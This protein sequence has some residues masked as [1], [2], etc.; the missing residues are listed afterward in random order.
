MPPESRPSLPHPDSAPGAIAARWFSQHSST[1]GIEV[2]IHFSGD[3]LLIDAGSARQSVSAAGLTVANGGYD[4]RTL[5]LSWDDESGL[6]LLHIADIDAQRA[7]RSAAPPALAP[8]LARWQRRSAVPW[9]GL[10]ITAAVVVLLIVGVISASGRLLDAVIAQVPIS[11]ES[12]FGE[13]MYAQLRRRQ[14]FAESGPAFDAVQM[15]GERLTKG[16]QYHYRWAIA[17]DPSIN[18][19]ALPGGIIVVHRG[20]ITAAQTPETLAGVLAHEVQHVERRHSLRALGHE[21]GWRLALGLILGD[22]SGTG[23]ALLSQLDGLGYSR[24][25]EREADHYG[26]LALAR[27]GIDPAGLPQFFETLAASAPDTVALLSTHPSSA[28]RLA[29]ARRDI[30]ALPAQSYTPLNLPWPPG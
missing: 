3:R 6:N 26:I 30:A 14:T 4:G 27:S 28:T 9:R 5:V 23:V 10:L 2:R 22:T 21:F 11:A 7:L 8:Q 24:D 17:E 29:D 12:E 25:L 15:I 18:A 1:T 13:T 19:F 20:L 16:S